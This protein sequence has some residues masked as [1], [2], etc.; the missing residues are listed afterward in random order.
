MDENTKLIFANSVKAENWEDGEKVT[1]DV[2]ILREEFRKRLYS[3][4][5][6]QAAAQSSQSKATDK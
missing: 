5:P 6:D 4:Q 2:A 1:D 3:H